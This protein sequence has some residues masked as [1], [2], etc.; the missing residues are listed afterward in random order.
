[1]PKCKT[2]NTY[3]KASWQTSLPHSPLWKKIMLRNQE[4]MHWKVLMTKG[5]STPLR[6]TTLGTSLVVQW[7]GLHLPT[8]G[9][10]IR[11]LVGKLGSHMPWGPRNQ[12]IKPRQGCGRFNEDFLNGPHWK[13]KKKKKY[14]LQIKSCKTH[15]VLQS[16]SKHQK[17]SKWR[18]FQVRGTQIIT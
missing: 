11:S 9:L 6:N 10:W 13:K 7:L 14:A 2:W 1:M 17:P 15:S 3:M 18:V 5:G 12:S 4:N 16:N 8:Q